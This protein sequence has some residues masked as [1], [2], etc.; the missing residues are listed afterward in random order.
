MPDLGSKPDS[1]KSNRREK[2]PKSSRILRPEDFGLVLRSPSPGLRFRR[3]IISLV[4]RM[5]KEPGRVRI[6]LT[7]GKHNVARAVDRVLVKRVMRE[8]I[9]NA[10]P[11]IREECLSRKIGLDV[12][13]RIREKFSCAG[14]EIS[15]KAQK[16]R[17]RRFTKDCVDSL[18]KKIRQLP[19]EEEKCLQKC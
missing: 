2:F 1:S 17:V 11:T 15:L 13:L 4:A 12:S 14:P 9:R 6:G 10:L 5:T 7:V 18:I 3:E 19:N 8:N 16:N